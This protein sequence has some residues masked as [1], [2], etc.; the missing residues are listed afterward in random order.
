VLLLTGRSL[1]VRTAITAFSVVLID[2]TTKLLATFLASRGVARGVLAPIQNASFSLG[3]AAAPVPMMLLLATAAI[4]CFGG[5]TGWQALRGKVSTWVPGL[6]IGG[7]VANLLDRL[8]FGAVHD[9]L[10]LPKVVINLADV[11]VVVGLSI[12]FISLI[13]PRRAGSNRSL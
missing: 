12:Y 2:A 10:Y 9:W 4:I 8:I 3:I 1:A 7:A 11:A 13:R 6:L 5:Y